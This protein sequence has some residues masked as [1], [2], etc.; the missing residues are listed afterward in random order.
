MSTQL[1]RD[2]R[3]LKFEIET[4]LAASAKAYYR[5]GIT[6][7][8]NAEAR[9]WE[10]YQAAVGNLAV[11]IE[12]MLKA[13]VARHCFRK[14][15]AGLPDELDLF[16]SQTET[17]PPS[18]SLRPF[19][20]ALRS[21]EQKTIDLNQAITIYEIYFPDKKL[22]LHSYFNFLATTRNVSVHGALPDFQRHNLNRVSYLAISVIKHLEEQKILTEP[23]DLALKTKDI[24]MGFDR[25]RV[26]CVTKKIKEARQIAKRLTGKRNAVFTNPHNF[27]ELVLPCPICGT[28]IVTSG[29]T[30]D[31]IVSEDD[32]SLTYFLNGFHCTECALEIDDPR[33]L[34][35]AGLSETYDRTDQWDEW[36]RQYADPY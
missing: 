25:E 29:Y 14:L 19:E 27:E 12:L 23:A 15:Y 35:L 2:L 7:Y 3:Q 21:F 18:V 34:R 11:A 22:E 1:P 24:L 5:I 10:S 8:L 26:E 30:E 33:D 13:F 31:K 16:L 9:M 28:E 32:A 17:P 36:C 4:N 6:E 20:D